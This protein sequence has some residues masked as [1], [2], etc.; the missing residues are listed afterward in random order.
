MSK[1]MLKVAILGANGFIGSRAV[2][3]LHLGG[4][5]QVR[6]IVRNVHALARLSKFDLD[7][8][9]ADGFDE[10]GLSKAFQ[11]CDV[12]VHA[13][14]G[15]SRTILGTLTPVYRAAEKAGV[16]RLIYLSSASV[17]GQAPSP[18]TDETSPLSDRQPIEYNNA[19]VRAEWKLRRLRDRGSVELVMLRPGI[20]F[21]PRS[22]WITSFA[23][24]LL[25]G[26]AYLVNGGQGICNSIYVDN[27]VHAIQLC[28][29][30]AKVDKEVFLV[31]D[32][33]QVTWFDL[34]APIAQA[35]GCEP[36]QIP[37]AQ[38]VS[39][40]PSI[41]DCIETVLASKPSLAF[42]SLFPDQWRQAARAALTILVQ[43]EPASS[44][45]LTPTQPSLLAPIATLEMIL[46]QQCWYKLP[47]TKAAHIFAYKPTISFQEALQRSTHWLDFSG[48]ALVNSRLNTVT[49]SFQDPTLNQ[50]R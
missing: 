15:D 45:Q 40:Q 7:G 37:N 1:P 16:Q 46:L 27:L 14:A 19:K 12:V 47:S 26:T 17:H 39:T 20:V 38:Y 9:V 13:I 30:A 34:Y 33:E 31:G 2:E 23:D 50:K 41:I 4:G 28:M 8:R 29:T 10:E 42:L 5:A 32:R 11:G 36:E 22:Y 3:M 25:N 49:D 24:S 48:Y 43:P 44:W 6:P 18:G 35:L 21:G